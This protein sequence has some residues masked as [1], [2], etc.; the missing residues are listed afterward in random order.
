M[1]PHQ[2]FLEVFSQL[3]VIGLLLFLLILWRLLWQFFAFCKRVHQ[4]QLRSE[5]VSLFCGL[6]GALVMGLFDSLWYHHG[7]FW[8]FWVLF[9]SWENLQREG[10]I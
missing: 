5:G 9:A 4:G 8:L 1:H 7:L 2:A 6:I 3:G 10:K